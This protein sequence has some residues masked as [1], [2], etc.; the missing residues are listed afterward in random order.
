MAPRFA[1]VDPIFTGLIDTMEVFK[2]KTFSVKA[3]TDWSQCT[4]GLQES[5]SCKRPVCK[6][7]QLN[8]FMPQRYRPMRKNSLAV[9]SGQILR[10][11]TR[12]AFETSKARGALAASAVFT[13]I[14]FHLTPFPAEPRLTRT[15]ER[16]GHVGAVAEDARAGEAA[17]RWM[18]TEWTRP[19]RGTCAA[20]QVKQ[21][22]THAL[23]VTRVWCAH[24]G[25][26]AAVPWL[27]AG[28]C[29]RKLLSLRSGELQLSVQVEREGEASNLHWAQAAG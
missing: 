9:F 5:S 20:V 26:P 4:T 13:H 3:L 8:S 11:E 15:L 2:K 21:V 17:V 7:E 22:L 19:L 27:T 25:S 29:P 18:L 28:V 14:N 12:V 1:W 24:A 23:V 6:S 16:P 10:A